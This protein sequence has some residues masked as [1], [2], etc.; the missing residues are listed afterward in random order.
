MPNFLGKE[1]ILC[2]K[3]YVFESIGLVSSSLTIA[4]GVFYTFLQKYGG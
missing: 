4:S 1:N 2:N 3:I